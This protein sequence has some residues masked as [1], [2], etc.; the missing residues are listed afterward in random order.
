MA[1]KLKH[2]VD[3]RISREKNLVEQEQSFILLNVR[4]KNTAVCPLDPE[5]QSVQQK[6]K[7]GNVKATILHV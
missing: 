2:Y 4:V 1:Q 3:L 5:N 7:K 6:V